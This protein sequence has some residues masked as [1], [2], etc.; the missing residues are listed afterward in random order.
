MYDIKGGGVTYINGMSSLA[1]KYEAHSDAI[2]SM[3]MTSKFNFDSV[4]M[5]LMKLSS[6]N[7]LQTSRL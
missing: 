1:D 3:M 4:N 5:F 6:L 7:T 2:N